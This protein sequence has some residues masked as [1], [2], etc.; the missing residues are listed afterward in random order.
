MHQ[1]SLANAD[2]QKVLDDVAEL[3]R[4]LQAAQDK[5]NTL[6]ASANAMQKQMDAANKLLTG[7]AGENTR[8][9]EDSKNFAKRRKMLIGDIAVV[10]AFVTYVGPFNTEFRQHLLELFLEDTMK[11]KVPAHEK[12]IP[13][14]FLVDASTIGEWGLEGLPNDDLSIQN[15]IMVTRS[16]RY[17]LMVDPQSQANRWIKKR[18][19]ARITV[20]PNMCVTTLSNRQLKDQIEFTMGEGL[21]L[22][23]ENVEN[24][25]DPML[26]PVLD[27]AIIKKGK[28]L[29]INVSDQNMD[30]SKK[31]SLY[32]TSRLPNPHFSPELSAKCTVIDFTVTLIGLEQQLLGRLIGMEQKSLEESLAQLKEECTNNMK[33]LQL[34]SSQLLERLS[35]STGNLLDDTELIEVLAN[36]KAKAKEVETKL[37][38]ADERTIEINEKREQFRPVA[39]RE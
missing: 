39:T 24:E 14:S 7:L 26:D 1:L 28:N 11:R 18:E 31:F 12:V 20:N 5:M 19:Q 4:Q 3:D 27:K 6:Q 25:V 2:L 35:N 10:C 23:I 8:W 30:Y 33:A 29:Y 13:E 22:V 15:A 32:M 34:L 36:T 16:S 21:C 38:E 9:T 37:K 17:P